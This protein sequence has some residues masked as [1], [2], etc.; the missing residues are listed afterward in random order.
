MNPLM[1]ALDLARHGR[2]QAAED[3]ARAVAQADP[4]NAEALVLLGLSIAATGHAERAAPALASAARLRPNLPHPC[5]ELAEALT[6]TV[7]I[8]RLFRACLRLNASD[9]ALRT[10]CATWLLDHDDPDGALTLARDG[11]DSPDLL[12]L[13]GM[14]LAEMGE[15]DAAAARFQALLARAPDRAGA[16]SN[17]GMMLKASGRHQEALAAHDEAVRLSPN[18]PLLRT[19]R[20]VTLLHAG[21]WREAWGDYDARLR[22]PDRV[23]LP[24]SSLLPDLARLPRDLSG[25]TILA[26]HEDGF[27]DTLHF[28]R[29]LPLLA[30]QGA[31][32]LAW[33]PDS[34]IRVVARLPGVTA[35]ALGGPVPAHD[36]HCPMFSLPRAFGSTPADVPSDP[37]LTPDPALVAS[38]ARRLPS[39]GF[40]VGIVWAG[41]SR[42]WLPGF[43]AIDR[44]RGIGLPALMLLDRIPGVRLVS[45]QKNAPAWPGLFDPMPGVRDFADTAAIIANLDLVVSVDTSVVHVAG[46]MGR[47]VFLLDRYDNC[48]R[49]LHGRADSP[50]YPSLTIFRQ[51][52]PL[53]WS[54]P[55]ARMGSAIAALAS[56]NAPPEA[57]AHPFPATEWRDAA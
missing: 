23:G 35:V 13:A 2:W 33:V 44:R 31:R 20:A 22:M 26:T 6:G 45:L 14:A 51:H 52:R 21:R 4:A 41:Q 43:A 30:R 27:G 25:V 18:A 9:D 32:V 24:L 40:R 53:D 19:N 49:W 15:F 10:A 46:A 11:G 17:L 38:W 7:S 34:L 12:H 55:L 39:Q 29:Y 56:F 3:A 37:Y 54:A 47:P 8:A 1:R 48:W 42:P 28:M 36:F 57:D 50:W 5:L 16:W